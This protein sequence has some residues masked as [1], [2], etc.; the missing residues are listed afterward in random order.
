MKNPDQ[1]KA[2]FDRRIKLDRDVNRLVDIF[3][4]DR[5][6]IPHVF[7]LLRKNIERNYPEVSISYKKGGKIKVKIHEGERE[8]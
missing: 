2:D 4:K 7:F 6:N 5:N 8:Y 1:I 3:T